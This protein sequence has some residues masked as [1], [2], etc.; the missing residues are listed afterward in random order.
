MHSLGKMF[1][2]SYEIPHSAG[3]SVKDV[4]DEFTLITTA[5]FH[6]E[7]VIR[8][9]KQTNKQNLD[10][11]NWNTL[12]SPQHDQLASWLFTSATGGWGEWF[13]MACQKTISN[14]QCEGEHEDNSGNY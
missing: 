6:L 12:H 5:G 11:Y 1:L 3:S 14:R 4:I 9:V 2:K 7:G 10:S 13:P 8:Q